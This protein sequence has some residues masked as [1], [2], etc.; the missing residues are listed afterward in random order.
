LFHGVLGGVYLVAF[1]SLW[2]QVDGLIGSRGILPA[3]RLLAW[4]RAQVGVERYWL[5]PTLCWLSG[6]DT[7]LHLLCA[8]GVALAI[9]L[10][11]DLAPALALALL[12]AF[13]LS[14]AN[15]G[16]VFLQY[17]WDS[18]LLETGFLAIFF[19]PLALRPRPSDEPSPI[20]LWLLRWLA[21]RLFFESGLVKRLSGDPTWRDLSALRY[22]YE[23]QPLPTWVGWYAHQLP[24]WFQTVSCAL[25]FVIELA[26][27]LLIFAPRRLRNAAAV[28][29]LGLQLL[30]ALTGNYGF[31]NLLAAALCIPLLDDRALPRRLFPLVPSASGSRAWH[32]A[33]LIPV[34]ALSVGV[35]GLELAGS[36]G[37]RP[38]PQPAV[39]LYRAVAPFSSIN[40]YGLFAMMTTSR[41]EV[42]IEGSDDGIDWSPYVFR[43]KA[44]ELGRAPAFVAPHQP[45]LDWQM[46]FAALGTCEENPWLVQLML[47]LQQASPPVLGLLELN[48]FPHAPPRLIRAM[49]YDYRFTDLATRRRDGTWWLRTLRG[50]YCPELAAPQSP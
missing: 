32:Q 13:Y 50:P 19:A 7:A 6:S 37:L 11:F 46:W 33:V 40:S 20:A 43:W 14:L 15:V 24:G 34:A 30:I 23:T 38:W 29:L 16:Q 21:F 10:M 39:A 3:E 26:V 1:A 12:W 25:V 4:A 28:A 8:G 31:F 22:H 2:V 44:G 48:P 41:P 5:L 27:P 9:A 47:R 45:R 35:S 17:Q 18:L 42:T 36:L 49:L